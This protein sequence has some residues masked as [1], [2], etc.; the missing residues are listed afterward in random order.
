[1]HFTSLFCL[2]LLPGGVVTL[3]CT[4]SLTY[5]LS[6]FLSIYCLISAIINYCLVVLVRQFRI[7]FARTFN[8][9]DKSHHQIQAKLISATESFCQLAPSQ[10][11]LRRCPRSW[12]M[13]WYWKFAFSSVQSIAEKTCSPIPVN[14]YSIRDLC[15]FMSSRWSSLYISGF[16]AHTLSVGKSFASSPRE[17]S[18]RGRSTR[19]T[20]I[21]KKEKEI[22]EVTH[23]HCRNVFWWWNDRGSILTI[24]TH[25]FLA[26]KR[27]VQITPIIWNCSIWQYT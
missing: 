18:H 6:H 23:L 10:P 21:H 17:R 25:S 19:K 20:H 22:S 12:N 4:S 26:R 15:D 27:G 11:Q 1:M 13:L 8:V 9:A 3:L 7:Y 2:S 5:T 14:I 16:S 24:Y